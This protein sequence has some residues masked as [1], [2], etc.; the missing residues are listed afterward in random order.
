MW[1][2]YARMK[3]ARRIFVKAMGFFTR[4][5][6]MACWNLHGNLPFKIDR[7]AKFEIISEKTEVDIKTTGD[8]K[9]LTLEERSQ[10]MKERPS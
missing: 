8:K 3:I 4:G 9:V 6:T 7:L 1:N 2:I 10:A 5:V